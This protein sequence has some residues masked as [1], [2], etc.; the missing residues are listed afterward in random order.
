[1]QPSQLAEATKPRLGCV[2]N[3]AIGFLMFNNKYSHYCTRNNYSLVLYLNNLTNVRIY[4][5]S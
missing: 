5:D 3:A 2:A 4:H 1:M